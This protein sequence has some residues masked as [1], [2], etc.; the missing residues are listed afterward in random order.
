MEMEYT[1]RYH[2]TEQAVTKYQL[3]RI[4]NGVLGVVGALV[5]TVLIFG[6]AAFIVLVFG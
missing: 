1:V 5:A 2:D 4:L 6:M 3:R